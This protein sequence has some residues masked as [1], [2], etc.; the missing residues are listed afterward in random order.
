M[1][2]V[3][4]AESPRDFGFRLR[5][6]IRSLLGYG[7]GLVFLFDNYKY[8]YVLFALSG[9]YEF[10]F[11]AFW[12]SVG[13]GHGRWH[14]PHRPR[15]PIHL[16]LLLGFGERRFHD[17]H[18]WVS[19]TWGGGLP[20]RSTSARA[21]AELHARPRP[22]RRVLPTLALLARSTVSQ[23]Y[24]KPYPHVRSHCAYRTLLTAHCS[25]S[26]YRSATRDSS[27]PRMASNSSRVICTA[28]S[29]SSAV[30]RM[31]A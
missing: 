29:P 19:G 16:D 5:V 31:P 26:S 21:P 15:T 25:L 23:V 1:H 28:C 6:K 3:P 18:N 30:A 17:W 20:S 27:G 22:A 8:C 9:L 4:S 10:S 24:M 2:P 12:R 13:L 14:S 7:N 11:F